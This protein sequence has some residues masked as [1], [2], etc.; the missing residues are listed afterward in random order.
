VF[1]SRVRP[2]IVGFGAAMIVTVAVPAA[3]LAA[4]PE[5]PVGGDLTPAPPDT[6]SMA[7]DTPPPPQAPLPEPPAWS[8]PAWS[9]PAPS[10]HSARPAAGVPSLSV[11]LWL[12]APRVAPGGVV[13]ATVRVSAAGA[14]AHHTVLSLSAPGAEVSS[15]GGLGDL[16]PGGRSV[17]RLV[18]I[19]A[20]H[21]PGVVTVTAMVHADHAAARASSADVTVASAGGALP[22]NLTVPG[23][24]MG[25]P[26]PGSAPELPV[27]AQTPDIA[28]EQSP[29]ATP[30]ALRAASSRLGLDAPAYRLA[31]TQT[32]WLVALLVALFFLTT[33]LRLRR[34]RR[35]RGGHRRRSLG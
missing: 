20:G 16:G 7:P 15:P 9:P 25:P 22:Q 17:V 12:S 33:Q 10:R 32:A 34:R 4:D 8:P 30:P 29:S 24:P 18:R 23:I 2:V 13:T 1:G 14:V 35:F 27:I 31:C 6:S 19:P 28:P 5:P 21:G 26:P 3:A 11:R